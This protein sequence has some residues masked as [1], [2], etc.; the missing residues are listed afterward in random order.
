MSDGQRRAV[1]VSR[2]RANRITPPSTQPESK[3]ATEDVTAAP[4]RL[5]TGKATTPESVSTPASETTRPGTKRPAKSGASPAV[6]ITGVD[7]ATTTQ[8]GTDTRKRGWFWHWNS[9]VTQFAPL[10]GLKGVGLLNSYTVWT[11]RRED[12]PNRGYAFPSQQSEADFY[13]EER[14]ELITINKIL[15]AL[16]LIEIRK[17]MILKPDAQGRQWRVPHNFYRV[18]DHDDGYV[19]SARAVLEVI[20]IADRDKNVY[21]YLRRI[22]S[23]RF[24]PIGSGSLWNDIMPVLRRDPTWQRLAAKVATEERRASDRTRAGHAARQSAAAAPVLFSVPGDGDNGAANGTC[25]D[26]GL[27]SGVAIGSPDATSVATGN[28]GSA[29]HIEVD[30]ASTNRGSGVNVAGSNR[31]LDGKRSS[32]VAG[33]NVAALTIVAPSN[34]MYDQSLSTTRTTTDTGS[35][36]EHRQDADIS[37]NR[38]SNRIAARRIGRVGGTTGATPMTDPVPVAT[39]VAPPVPAV[40]RAWPAAD[41][42]GPD[43][44]A[45]AIRAFEDANDK[46]STTAQRQLL[47]TLAEQFDAAARDSDTG[48]TGWVWVTAAIYEAVESGSAYVAPRRIREILARWQR[49]GRPSGDDGPG[50]GG[51]RVTG[52]SGRSS[53]SWNDTSVRSGRAAVGATPAFVPGKAPARRPAVVGQQTVA[54]TDPIV[55]VRTGPRRTGPHRPTASSSATT[56]V[57]DTAVPVVAPLS[58]RTAPADTTFVVEECGLASTQVWSAMLTELALGGEISRADLESCIR[59]AE[60]VGRGEG[61]ELMIGASSAVT[62]RRASRYLPV[63]RRA[64]ETIIGVPVPVEVSVR[65]VWLAEHP[66]RRAAGRSDANRRSSG[67]Q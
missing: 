48:S 54:P 12:S 66:D 22:F 44:G 51:R 7:A 8:S 28:K 30:V 60:L 31:G 2:V 35:T 34:T 32:S 58:R 67:G 59:S 62:Q 63:I 19:L 56:Q 46:P 45:T 13:G 25:S 40:I 36:D 1:R 20:Q 27:P 4:V 17:E 55:S 49:E 26:S 43:A 23:T 18:K 21:R 29:G 24:S 3:A 11:D 41:G 61:G 39:P 57:S 47:T 9:I 38:L 5:A 6:D 50:R 52:D 16:D 14:S 65:S 64:A 15:V 33:S 53:A 10:I 37:R 42:A